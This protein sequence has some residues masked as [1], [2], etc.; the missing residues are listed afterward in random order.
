MWYIV[1]TYP[2]Y[3]SSNL[4][5]KIQGC[6]VDSVV[7]RSLPAFLGRRAPAQQCGD[8]ASGETGACSY[9][10]SGDSPDEAATHRVKTLLGRSIPTHV[11]TEKKP[12]ITSLPT[13]RFEP[14]TLS[15]RTLV[16]SFATVLASRIAGIDAKHYLMAGGSIRKNK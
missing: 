3:V 10:R 9:K 7:S 12:R 13:T 15:S 14:R 5:C 6:G 11:T 4:D 16:L 8:E 2:D 1:R